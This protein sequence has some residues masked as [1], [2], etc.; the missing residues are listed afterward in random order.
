VTAATTASNIAPSDLKEISAIFPIVPPKK[1]ARLLVLRENIEN[2]SW[3]G[4]FGFPPHQQ[5]NGRREPHE[6]DAWR[7]SLTGARSRMQ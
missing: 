5:N 3:S 4:S 6:S 2:R 7:Y 1:I